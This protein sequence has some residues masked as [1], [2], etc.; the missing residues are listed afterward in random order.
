MAELTTASVA[1]V[2]TGA[3]GTAFLT[4]L[5][6]EPAPLFWALV[7]A[8]LG[9]TFAPA[10]NRVRAS[11]VFGGVVLCSSLFGAWLAHRYAGGEPIS[12]NAFSCFLALFF[13]PSVSL[14]L[15]KMPAL[16]DA[17]VNRLVGSPGAE[18][19]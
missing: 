11:V 3:A 2:L 10:A 5:G 13:H 9:I 14:A 15:T 19:P 4:Y 18:K 8:S 17:V 1:P 6:L 16:W 12:R 7:G